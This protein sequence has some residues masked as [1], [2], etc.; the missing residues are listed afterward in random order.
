MTR[1]T[2]TLLSVLLYCLL[3]GAAA[4][5]DATDDGAPAAGQADHPEHRGEAPAGGR[6]E[7]TMTN[8]RLAGLLARID[9]EAEGRP[10]LWRLRYQDY[11]V[12]V[13]TDENADR[14]R[15][16]VP[17]A[18]A[19]GLDPAMLERLMQANFDAALDARYALARGE[20][21]AVFIHPLASLSE[22][23]FFSGLAQALNLAATYGTTYSSGALLFGGGDSASQQRQYYESIMERAN[24]I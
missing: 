22:H 8:E 9:P 14:M 7:G 13:I 20:I 12:L 18:D 15:I 6:S 19:A 11:P 23:E 10:G 17:V 3:P 24:A 21:L 4:A 16:V 1:T 2:A 5:M